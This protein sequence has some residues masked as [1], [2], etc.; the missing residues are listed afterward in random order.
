M[1]ASVIRYRKLVTTDVA[2]QA[3][4]LAESGTMGHR[5]QIPVSV[6]D[7]N[8]IFVWDRPAGSDRPVGHFNADTIP[9]D[10]I[11]SNS[12]S[13][14]YT[15]IDGVTNGLN[16]SSAILD[17]NNDSRVRKGGNVLAN[18]LVMC[19]V[20][21]KCYGSSSAPTEGVVYNLQDAQDMLSNGALVSAIHTSMAN[22]EV[23][24]NNPGVDKGA[25]DAMFRDLL[26]ADPSR[27]FD[28]AGRQITGLFET[29]ADMDARG[30]W[31][32]VENDKI[33]IAVQMR[34]VNPVT[35][36]AVGDGEDTTQTV[37][38][39]AGSTFKIRLQLV[40]TDTPSGAAA[41]E[42]VAQA[43]TS[44]VINA[45]ADATAKA[46]ANAATAQRAATQAVSAAA[47]QSTT[48][49]ARYQKA[50]ED[51]AKQAAAVAKA[52]A[53]LQAAKANLNQAIISGRTDSEIQNQRAAS[54]AAQALV[55]N[56][57]A[58]A[59]LASADLQNAKNSTDSATA[60]LAA[61]QIA[62]ATA[63]SNLA[64]ANAAAALAA[65][66]KA[67]DAAS[68]AET[69]KAAADAASDPITQ[70][71]T[72]SESVI[73][74]PQTI[75]TLDAA[76]SSATIQ[77]SEA[78]TND[79]TTQ[80]KQIIATEKY[81]IIRYN[82][83][84]AISLGKTESEIQILRTQLSRAL[85]DKTVAD[86]EASA[87]QSTLTSYYNIES[88]ALSASIQAKKDAAVL[89]AR[90]AA[91]NTSDALRKLTVA[92][93]AFAYAST[94]TADALD[95]VNLA[96][97]TL[98]ARISGGSTFNELQTRRKAVLDANAFLS[99]QKAASA[100]AAATMA[101]CQAAVNKAQA[102]KT[103][104]DSKVVAV[105]TESEYMVSLYQSTIAASMSYQAQ[106][107]TDASANQLN[108]DVTNSLVQLNIAK[109]K[110]A[111]ANSV[112]NIAKR[113]LDAAL[114]GG[115]RLAEITILKGISQ[116]AELEKQRS[117]LILQEAQANYNKYVSTSSSEVAQEILNSAAQFQ[118]TQIAKA[119]AVTKAI[120]YNSTLSFYLDASANLAQARAADEI[121]EENLRAAIIG[122]MPLAQTT[123]L[124][125]QK[126]D[127]SNTYVKALADF[128]SASATM[129]TVSVGVTENPNVA[130]IL[131]SAQVLRESEIATAKSSE[132]MRKA[133]EVFTE[134]MNVVY[135][136]NF[137]DKNGEALKDM[138]ATALAGG[139]GL[140]EIS[141][142][143]ES[144]RKNRIQYANLFMKY[145]Q[146]S[147]QYDDISA[148]VSADPSLISNL[149][150]ADN[151][152]NYNT[153]YTRASQEI[154]DLT[155]AQIAKNTAQTDLTS[156]Q[157]E[158]YVITEEVN[159]AVRQGQTT[160]E[161]ANLT[162]T[163]NGVQTEL[164]N[165]M[166]ILN[167]A[168]KA[169]S[170]SQGN[171]NTFKTSI[172]PT[173][174]NTS[175]IQRQDNTYNTI[176]STLNANVSSLTRSISSAKS[177]MLT[178]NLTQTYID[179][180]HL[181][182]MV[183]E[184]NNL[185]EVTNEAFNTAIAQG[186]TLAEIQGLRLKLQEYSAKKVT[187]SSDLIN[188]T[189][190][191]HSSLQIAAQSE[192]VKGILDVVAKMQTIVL[193]GAKSNEL[194]RNLI[195]A[196][197]VAYNLSI[198]DTAA[199]SELL[200]AQSALEI[201]TA[202]GTIDQEKYDAI[203]AA[204]NKVATIRNKLT[205]ANAAVALANTH[206][207]MD[208]NVQTLQDL[209][210]VN[211]E[212]QNAIAQANMLSEQYFAAKAAEAKAYAALE[213][214]KKSLASASALFDTAISSGT[215]IIAIQKARDDLNA[216]ASQLN[217]A[218]SKEEYA[219]AALNTAL[220]N[221]N[222]SQTAQALITTARV[223]D[224][225]VVAGANVTTEQYN[226]DLLMARLTDATAV[227]QAS[228]EKASSE[229][230]IL[231]IATQP[232]PPIVEYTYS[233]NPIDS[234]IFNTNNTITINGNLIGNNSTTGNKYFSFIPGQTDK[235][236]YASFRTPTDLQIGPYFILWSNGTYSVY[237]GTTTLRTG[238]YTTSTD[239]GLYYDQT[240]VHYY[241]NGVKVFSS[242]ISEAELHIS[243]FKWT[244]DG[245]IIT[246][247]YEGVSPN[248]GS[249]GRTIQEVSLL[250]QNAAA[251]S[252]KASADMHAMRILQKQILD[253]QDIV[254]KYTAIYQATQDAV[255]TNNVINY[256][257][258]N[259]F[260]FQQSINRYV[261]NK[262]R[263]PATVTEGVDIVLYSQT[264][265]PIDVGIYSNT[266]S[267][268]IGNLVTYPDDSSPQYMCLVGTDPR[269]Q[270]FSS[271]TGRSP[272]TSPIA[273][274]KT[275]E[276][277]IRY[278]SATDLMSTN[279][280]SNAP[281][282]VSINLTGDL[283]GL[284]TLFLNSD[285]SGNNTLLNGLVI[286]GSSVPTSNFLDR[287]TIT[288]ASYNSQRTIL[289]LTIS[290]PVAIVD[291]TSVL[292]IKSGKTVLTAAVLAYNTYMTN[293]AAA[294]F[295]PVTTI[296][297][298][299]KSFVNRSM[300]PTPITPGTP[301]ALGTSTITPTSRGLYSPTTSYTTGDI[302]MDQYESVYMCTVG[303]DSRGASYATTVGNAPVEHP[304]SSIYWYIV[305]NNS[306]D[307]FVYDSAN[308]LQLTPVAFGTG[309]IYWTS[310][311]FPAN[312][313]I[314][315]ASSLLTGYTMFGTGI[316]QRNTIT[317]L[318]YGY[319]GSTFSYIFTQGETLKDLTK[320]FYV[321]N[322]KSALSSNTLSR[323]F[324][325]LSTLLSSA[326]S[327]LNTIASKTTIED[328]EIVIAN[329][330][331]L[332]NTVLAIQ[333]FYTGNT[334][335]LPCINLAVS[336]MAECVKSGQS[337]KTVLNYYLTAVSGGVTSEISDMQTSKTAVS[338]Y[339]TTVVNQM[340]AASN[341][342][343]L[344]DL[345]NS[346]IKLTTIQTTNISMAVSANEYAYY[347]VTPT[348]IGYT[349]LDTNNSGGVNYGLPMGTSLRAYIETPTQSNLWNIDSS[350]YTLEFITTA[351]DNWNNSG[352]LIDRFAQPSTATILMGLNAASNTGTQFAL[353]N[354][355]A[356][357]GLLGFSG[358][359][360]T[361]GPLY[362]NTSE[363]GF[364]GTFSSNASNYY[365][366]G[367]A[368]NHYCEVRKNNVQTVY[369]N[370]NQMMQYSNIY[371]APSNSVVPS[372]GCNSAINTYGPSPPYWQIGG[373][374]TIMGQGGTPWVGGL[375]NI[376]LSKEAIYTS[377]FNTSSTIKGPNSVFF[378]NLECLSTTIL[379][380]PMNNASLLRDYGIAHLRVSTMAYSS[381]I[382][383]TIKY[384]SSF[385][386]PSSFTSLAISPVCYLP[387][388]TNTLNL[389]S[390]GFSPTITG[391][392]NTFSTV[393]ARTGVVFNGTW[394]NSISATFNPI[395][396]IT[397]SFWEYCTGGSTA[398]GLYGNGYFGNFASLYDSYDN[399]SGSSNSWVNVN[400]VNGGGM[401]SGY[402]KNRGIGSSFMKPKSWNQ[403]SL[404]LY[405]DSN[406]RVNSVSYINGVYS[407]S[408]NVIYDSNNTYDNSNILNTS[409]VLGNTFTQVSPTSISATAGNWSVVTYSSNSYKESCYLSYTIDATS[410][411]SVS[412]GLSD[413][414]S[415]AIYNPKYSF[416]IQGSGAW[417][418]IHDSGGSYGFVGEGAQTSASVYSIGY[419]GTN[420]YW[421]VNGVLK[422]TT[423]R[424]VGKPLYAVMSP[425]SSPN[426]IKANN[427]YFASSYIVGTSI[428]RPT[429]ISNTTV[430][431]YNA[432]RT[433]NRITIGR[434]ERND[435]QQLYPWK[436][437][438]KDVMVFD[439]ALTSTQIFALYTEQLYSAR[440]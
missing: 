366:F 211:Y 126:I 168:N 314:Q 177:N 281:Y 128:N 141:Q 346:A 386:A 403:I 228:L 40:A 404:V 194:L 203:V 325:T 7:L 368:Q 200:L 10:T 185:Y 369:L 225:N 39:P 226:L 405:S 25:I 16:F 133:N 5:V 355:G 188:K 149:L 276:G 46:A 235:E 310:A 348:Q 49:K 13:K 179:M 173:N 351:G 417:V 393:N 437:M 180:L 101:D 103:A 240:N 391:T 214:A 31:G 387:L 288:A 64:L 378:K 370:G 319:S 427:I 322:G 127:H 421:Y 115:K 213:V 347:Y 118:S 91:A 428:S 356:W 66:A 163:L 244:Q 394:S 284:Q 137:T 183:I 9:F 411:G 50:V 332:Q 111:S 67:D 63:A 14:I 122:G 100:A 291:N 329:I 266:E 398:L 132:L 320:T 341:Y 182:T 56:L 26:A 102:L 104:A 55:D 148:Q 17:A 68:A 269:N 307:S 167:I 37:V 279:L 363:I 344:Q 396:S 248:P 221:A 358:N 157:A 227:S 60:A 434:A 170:T 315:L 301:F 277:A 275:Q 280:I 155:N 53:A 304:G 259:G 27:F 70:A 436:G 295:T 61:A 143:Q 22:E 231:D 147:A 3:V 410:A 252:Q 74:D 278:V 186:Q 265:T 210:E 364:G 389:G 89:S 107:V 189:A 264:I 384:L 241:V 424:S 408:N 308:D 43:N 273:W 402:F 395:S 299:T 361:W 338:T 303:Q 15:D 420:I 114:A 418:S 439:K 250:R 169:L 380:L 134:F 342:Y 371:S 6:D 222:L 382:N 58:I 388:S 313:N 162:S 154:K 381:N 423:A 272:D 354:W 71:I 383:S 38:I 78:Q 372:A 232:P 44:A 36:Q 385:T 349:L 340:N 432:M 21:Y 131:Y 139:K 302:V 99:T 153:I 187:D 233:A 409:W 317:N 138:L 323:V 400:F 164:A 97:N 32:F 11:L 312:P 283:I 93:N 62:A 257:L 260:S 316:Y 204:S 263:V 193:D 195:S 360:N 333:T 86:L 85:A 35:R 219:K 406:N 59:D 376:R 98:D 306:W 47:A 243:V 274:I 311:D 176:A 145:E 23:L 223:T 175:I 285:A 294:G 34:F 121:C 95:S 261:L 247:L 109:D 199:Q 251:A 258:F 113:N 52:Q 431:T 216:A 106:K 293:L 286:F 202:N 51:N 242:P 146:L 416:N 377:P 4:N 2:S 335:L 112:Y 207:N 151:V 45:Q 152:L 28:A 253:Q 198:Q 8:T 209:A 229:Q 80:A 156:K 19:Y 208:P 287:A 136:G 120:I 205:A 33:E 373:Q 328:V 327:Q 374:S 158:Y 292:Y 174:E 1:S 390:D 96:Q 65:K 256:M 30:N 41:K 57:E 82:I 254:N 326:A 350:D 190:A 197:N 110:F 234:I 337:A 433:I 267:Y 365:N 425:A 440:L 435:E 298:L 150:N 48:A 215:D 345:T 255:A 239:F 415:P 414:L 94:I 224:D 426:F 343:I 81:N 166:T 412:F 124:R 116:D 160:A 171:W 217:D 438:I 18:D 268:V 334:T 246:N 289:T 282:T 129:S 108:L 375:R 83:D 336:I 212:Q 270:S 392:V 359:T 290:K 220:V 237:E 88:R 79:S 77:R 422:R 75:V 119:E 309:Q 105:N 140:D 172:Y 87:T 130:D 330:V 401:T 321:K 72:N 12:L 29:V 178:K 196:K 362:S 76:V 407:S 300:L 123:V 142:L 397:V 117:E 192:N 92:T 161:T 191:Y 144:L 318:S 262:D 367:S 42:E 399:A 245:V 184:D 24:T 54:V 339:I 206:V 249:S 230:T 331:T 324:S 413:S 165:K 20:I 201:A 181:S 135:D 159:T 84:Y 357:R 218:N 353:A 379:L 297:S 236:L 90:I 429:L 69:A 238:V 352:Q 73:L 271:I 296:G 419:D 305:V 430:S 125:N